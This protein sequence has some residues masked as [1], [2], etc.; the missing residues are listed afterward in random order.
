MLQMRCTVHQPLA[1]RAIRPHIKTQSL[2]N[3]SSRM[4]RVFDGV[5]VEVTIR[6]RA[7]L[8]PM[9]GDR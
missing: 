5:G 8:S 9:R 7:A 6:R 1:L 2:T 4:V 3:S